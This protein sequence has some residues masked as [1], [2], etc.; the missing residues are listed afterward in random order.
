MTT[1]AL[2]VRARGRQTAE[3]QARYEADLQAFCAAILEIRS[4]LDFQVSS[5]GWCYILEEHGL[6]KGAFD[7]AERLIVACRKSG[8]LPLDICADDRARAADNLEDLDETSPEEEA[9]DIIAAVRW[10]PDYYTPSS[11][12]EDQDHYLEMLVEKV[13]L[14]SLFSPICEEFYIPITN[15][16]GWTGLNSRADMMRRLARWEARGKRCILLYCGDHDPV[17][18]VISARI[19]A[20][21]AE[22]TTQ[23]GWSPD[24][25][26]I[27]RFGL[28]ADFIESQRLTWIDGLETGSGKNLADRSHPD[29]QKDYVQDYLR[30][31]G[32]KKVEANA[33][34]VRPDEG[35]QLCR[36]TILRY[37]HED[38]SEAYLRRLEPLR[39]QVRREVARLMERRP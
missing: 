20:N 7:A 32:P 36:A 3:A 6:A 23:V 13:D 39:A 2:P 11:F 16:R 29:H 18:L 14:K 35:R 4:R 10:R 24:N 25:L 37:V 1:I 31:F 17:G 19:R 12:W 38:A 8:D 26:A 30:R 28:N 27:D 34:V 21:M 33:L 9:A 5:R 22:L 15:G